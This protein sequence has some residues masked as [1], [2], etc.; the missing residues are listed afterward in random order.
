M[1][2]AA[3]A[4]HSAWVCAVVMAPEMSTHSTSVSVAHH[5]AIAALSVAEPPGIVQAITVVIGRAALMRV[6]ASL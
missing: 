1:I 3:T 4:S 2:A 6:A 5:A